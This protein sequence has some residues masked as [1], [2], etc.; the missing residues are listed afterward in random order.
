MS[1]RKSLTAK[2]AGGAKAD[3]F[4]RQ[5]HGER[6]RQKI[7]ETAVELFAEKG[8]RGTGI[9]TLAKKVGM[10]G[11]GLLYYFG[12]KERLLLDVMPERHRVE[13]P[14]HQSRVRLT[15]LRR[16]GRRTTSARRLAQLYVVL[17]AEAID[18]EHPLHDFFVERY[19]RN[20]QMARRLLTIERKEGRL[21]AD[22]DIDQLA[23]EI[24]AMT[25]GLEMLWL[26]DPDTF[27][28][29]TAL[30]KFYDRTE[31]DLAPE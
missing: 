8:F 20:H 16:S 21:R 2:T 9:A 7:V 27:D 1:T 15:D 18:P 31:R 22:A 13:L 4:E 3:G 12:T 28:F 26:T 6:T 25:L 10:S 17:G 19:R 11:P 5:D 23:I 29:R 24:Q 14:L 30:E